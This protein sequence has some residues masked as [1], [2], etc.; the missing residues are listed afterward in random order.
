VRRFL[1]RE[2]FAFLKPENLSYTDIWIK[3]GQELQVWVVVPAV[4]KKLVW[5]FPLFPR[6]N[7][8]P[9]SQYNASTETHECET[10]VFEQNDVYQA[11]NICLSKKK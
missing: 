4:I 9:S 10:T 1:Q 6:K 2:R 11:I 3:N 7:S 5:K 8:S